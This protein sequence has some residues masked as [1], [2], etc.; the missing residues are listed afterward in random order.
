MILQILLSHIFYQLSEDGKEKKDW[1]LYCWFHSF[2]GCYLGVGRNLS[3]KDPHKTILHACFF[4]FFLDFLKSLLLSLFGVLSFLI[5]FQFK[6]LSGQIKASSSY[7]LV[8]DPKAQHGGCFFYYFRTL[9]IQ[10]ACCSLKSQHILLYW[11]QSKQLIPELLAAHL[12]DLQRELLLG[13]K[14][15]YSL[16]LFS[17]KSKDTHP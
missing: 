5:F 7:L 16:N 10:N 11:G 15:L 6:V 13:W 17:C 2:H 14:C 4:F 9:G 12:S 3:H 1:S 8:S